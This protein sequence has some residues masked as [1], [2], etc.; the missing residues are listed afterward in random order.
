M[1]IEDF[2]LVFGATSVADAFGAEITA[3]VSAHAAA[4]AAIFL[5][6]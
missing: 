5:I 3:A 6:K 2:A 4:H 1:S